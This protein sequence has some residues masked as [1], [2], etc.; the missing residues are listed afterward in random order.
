MTSCIIKDNPTQNTGI[1]RLCINII[2]VLSVIAFALLLAFGL[3]YTVYFDIYANSDNPVAGK[4]NLLLLAFLTVIC[5]IVIYFIVYHTNVLSAD[6]KISRLLTCL[7][8]FTAVVCLYLIYGVKGQPNSDAAQVGNAV[9]AFLNGDFS[10]LSEVGSYFCLCP[11]QLGYAAAEMLISVIFGRN[12]YVAYE[13]VNVISILITLYV[14]YKI[15]SELF[16]NKG[17]RGIT[18]I[19]SFGMLYLYLYSTYF[20]GDIWSLAPEIAAIHFAIVY[21]KRRRVCDVILCGLTIGLACLLKNNCVIALIA[22]VIVLLLTFVNDV[23]VKKFKSG[24]RMLLSVICIIAIWFA[25]KEALAFGFERAAGVDSIPKGIPSSCYIAMGLHDQEFRSGWFDH[26]NWSFY[27]DNNYDWAAADAAARADIA[28]TLSSWAKRPWHGAKVLLQKNI[29]MWADPTCASIHQ[30]EYT[31][32]HSDGRTALVMS[33]TYGTGRTIISWIM[34]VWQTI[35]YLGTFIYCIFAIKHRKEIKLCQILPLLFILGGI[36]FLTIWEANSRSTVRYMN[37]MVIYG[38]F[39]ID[40]LF[41]WMRSKSLS[42][43]RK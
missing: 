34:N 18:V 27:Q 33:L 22:I 25:M 16:E 17:V 5:L 6:K 41:S 14:L 12:N 11:H 43:S 26:S 23:S 13:I 1:V 24:L 40:K 8:V 2:L 42:K 35:V 9:E 21:M 39:G 38:A 30:F 37:V 15:S 32:R 36:M 19:L 20:Y 3:V 10:E 28:E 29:S 31:G 4:E 7:L